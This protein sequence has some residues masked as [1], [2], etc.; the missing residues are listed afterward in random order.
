M[1]LIDKFEQNILNPN[2][3]FYSCCE[4]LLGFKIDSKLSF[5][6]HFISRGK[7]KTE[8]VGGTTPYMNCPF[9][10][11]IQMLHMLHR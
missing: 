9:I 10:S 1:S 3:G 6:E 4:K 11:L 2:R 7:Q 8:G 5:N